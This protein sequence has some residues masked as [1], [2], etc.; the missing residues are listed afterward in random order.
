MEDY[1][2]SAGWTG[3]DIDNALIN[4]GGISFG[5]EGNGFFKFTST[6]S[7]VDTKNND[8]PNIGN[9]LDAG[10]PRYSLVPQDALHEVVKV[11]TYG[12]KK[13]SDDNWK[14]VPDLQRRYKDA[15]GRHEYQNQS[16]DFD[17]ETGLYH[18]AHKICCDMFR[19]QSKIDEAKL[20]GGE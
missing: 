9:K 1:E 14:R 19:L 20:K 17:D 7:Q 8:V 13:Y 18:L 12:A 10:K 15:A 6:M 16:A 2:T 3:V 5:E 11:L 4:H